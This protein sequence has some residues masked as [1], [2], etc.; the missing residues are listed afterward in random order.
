MYKTFYALLT[1]VWVLDILNLPFV[2]V[3]DT[4]YAINGWTWFWI[5]VLLPSTKQVNT[6]KFEIDKD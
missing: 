1:I 5:W 3:L 2:E 4:T 6:H